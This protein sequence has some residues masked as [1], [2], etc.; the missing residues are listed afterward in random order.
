MVVCAALKIEVNVDGIDK[1]LVLPCHRHGDGF[2][3]LKELNQRARVL[4]EGFILHDGSF[5]DRKEALVH[6]EMC[7]QLSQIV[8]W[9][10][11]DRHIEEL[12]SEDLY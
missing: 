2:A 1:Q 4:S 11:E 10:K 6:A 8:K 7:G 12:F 5:A 3:F 9:D